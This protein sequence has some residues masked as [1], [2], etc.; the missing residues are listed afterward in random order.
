MTLLSYTDYDLNNPL[1]TV[2]FIQIIIQTKYD[3]HMYQFVLTI[4]PT[5]Y[6]SDLTISLLYIISLPR[7][8]LLK[9]S[10]TFI[11]HVLSHYEYGAC[12]NGCMSV[13]RS[14]TAAKCV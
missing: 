6:S 11:V 5:S 13:W 4:K 9:C 3:I 10:V 12:E 2:M 7:T 8:E 1:I 14:D